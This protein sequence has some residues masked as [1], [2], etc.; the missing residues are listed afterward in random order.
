MACEYQAARL[1]FQLQKN[2]AVVCKPKDSGSREQE[3]DSPTLSQVSAD[4]INKDP[5]FLLFL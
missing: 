1:H 5:Q 3:V 4:S 2:T